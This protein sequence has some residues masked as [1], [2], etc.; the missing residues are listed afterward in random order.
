M[1][2]GHETMKVAESAWQNNFYCYRRASHIMLHSKKVKTRL[3]VVEKTSTSLSQSFGT[4]MAK[5]HNCI[6]RSRIVYIDTTGFL[7]M[8]RPRGN[9]GSAR[10]TA[11]PSP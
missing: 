8:A 9:L 3:S 2:S 1:G 11:G 10:E 4:V 6:P 5:V 7:F